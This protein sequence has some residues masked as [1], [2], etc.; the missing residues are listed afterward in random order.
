[1]KIVRKRHFAVAHFALV[2]KRNLE[3]RNVRGKASKASL[4]VHVCVFRSRTSFT[5]FLRK[6]TELVWGLL[7]GVLSGA[8]MAAVEGRVI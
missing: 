4:D 3:Q 8:R 7:S 5:K 2:T 1:M 6:R